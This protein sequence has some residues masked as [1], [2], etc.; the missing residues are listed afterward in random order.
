MTGSAALLELELL[1]LEPDD[2]EVDDVPLFDISISFCTV[3]EKFRLSKTL[4]EI[5]HIVCNK[6]RSPKNS[7]KFW[8]LKSGLVKIS[9]S[10]A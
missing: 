3:T 10:G 7:Y 4:I 6:L 1:E 5:M 9:M 2:P 8:F